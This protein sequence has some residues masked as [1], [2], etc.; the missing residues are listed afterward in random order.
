MYHSLGAGEVLPVIST[1]GGRGGF[2]TIPR[3]MG[4]VPTYI[5]NSFHT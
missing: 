3:L 5:L 4:N 1:S 2:K